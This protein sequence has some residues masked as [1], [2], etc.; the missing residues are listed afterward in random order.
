MLFDSLCLQGTE[1]EDEEAI[2]ASLKEC[3][4]KVQPSEGKMTT[5]VKPVY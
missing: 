5:K 1:E 4:E 3:S 2:L